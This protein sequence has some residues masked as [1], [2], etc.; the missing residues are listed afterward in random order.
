M[1]LGGEPGG[2]HG[3]ERVCGQG[4]APRPEL[5]INSVRR[6]PRPRP[7]IGEPEADQLAEHLADFGRRREVS[8]RAQRIAGSVIVG[9]GETHILRDRDRPAR[10]D[11]IRQA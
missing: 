10:L 1:D 7:Q 6:R 9:I 5:E 4:A 8:R 11:Q 2:A 3:A